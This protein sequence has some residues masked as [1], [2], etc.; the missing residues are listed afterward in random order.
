M[1][2]FTS[3]SPG[4]AAKPDRSKK[5]RRRKFCDFR[6]KIGDFFVIF[7]EIY[8]GGYPKKS[9]IFGY[10]P[11]DFSFLRVP[12][13]D[14]SFLRVPPYRFRFLGTPPIDSVRITPKKI[15]DFL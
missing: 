1:I 5:R 4:R 13:I 11:I 2:L 7:G 14:F 3:K 10:P 9:R 8:R 15:I 6:P 12:P